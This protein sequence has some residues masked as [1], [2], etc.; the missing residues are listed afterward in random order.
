MYEMNN[1]VWWIVVTELLVLCMGY[2]DQGYPHRLTCFTC[3]K[4]SSNSA[5]N[6]VAVDRPCPAGLDTC[7]TV[8]HMT[9][10]SSNTVQYFTS[11]VVKMCSTRSDCSMMAGCRMR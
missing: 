2:R 10:Q 9:G 4:S 3:L 7:R 6:A 11:A 5:C 8:H 1:T